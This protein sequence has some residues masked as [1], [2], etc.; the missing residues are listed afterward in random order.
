MSVEVEKSDKREL[1]EWI[2][3][4]VLS[5]TLP[6][7]KNLEICAEANSHDVGLVSD[8]LG[9]SIV[10][11]QD[12]DR[13]AKATRVSRKS[14]WNED[15]EYKIRCCLEDLYLWTQSVDPLQRSLGESQSLHDTILECL[16]GIGMTLLGN[17]YFL[18][19]T[20][21]MVPRVLSI[22]LS[23][24]ATTLSDV[25]TYPKHLIGLVTVH[26]LGPENMIK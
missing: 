23:T 12:I 10:A 15:Q 17:Y 18:I 19:F 24:G 8:L 5:T 1:E 4:Y 25:K 16:Y 20:R 3:G 21:V 7:T 2:D 22:S 11:L 9:V 26:I 14:C 6:L 13:A